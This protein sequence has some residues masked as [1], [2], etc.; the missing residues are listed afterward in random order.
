MFF[1]KKDRENLQ[2]ILHNIVSGKDAIINQYEGI[3]ERQQKMLDGLYEKL[4]AKNLPEYK[5]Y[6]MPEI[7]KITP[8]DPMSD[9]NLAGTM[10]NIE[11]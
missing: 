5:T 3:I 6:V 2:V 4:L 8:Y 11:N 10:Q 9:E 7:E 1:T